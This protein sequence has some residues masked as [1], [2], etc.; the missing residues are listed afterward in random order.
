[1]PDYLSFKVTVNLPKLLKFGTELRERLMYRILEELRKS[2]PIGDDPGGGELK[3]SWYV[4]EVTGQTKDSIIFTNDSKQAL[5]L[6]RGTGKYGPSG[7][8]IYAPPG[9]TFVFRWRYG[10]NKL[11]FRKAVAGINPRN[12]G[13]G[14]GYDFDADNRD[15]V[16]A[17]VVRA[18]GEQI[19]ELTR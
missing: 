18:F 15:A 5:Y 16:N 4:D 13:Y 11:Y 9:K 19:R 8:P 17:G 6:S 2:S 14:V 10:G 7:L 3:N 1:M 12:I